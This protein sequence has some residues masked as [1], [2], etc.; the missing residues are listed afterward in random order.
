[1]TSTGNGLVNDDKNFMSQAGIRRSG[2]KGT[3][4]NWN[5]DNLFA[6]QW[7]LDQ[8]NIDRFDPFITGYAFV[9][10]TKLPRFFDTAFATEFKA[11][12]ERNFKSFDGI[13]D[14]Q[15]STEDMTHGF[16]GNA[17]GIATNI[18][19]ENTSFTLKHQELQGSPVRELYQYWTTGIR[20]PESG[21]AHYHGKMTGDNPLLYSMQNHT[22]ELLYVVTDPSGSTN[23]IE[24]AAYYTN[25]FPTKIPLGHLNY[26][27]GDHGLAEIDIE[28]RGNMHIGYY[29]NDL[30]KKLMVDYEVK[31][32]YGQYELGAVKTPAPHTGDGYGETATPYA[33]T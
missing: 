14:I 18:N 8:T 33:T 27:S 28:F 17:M 11:L 6:G 23:G 9:I 7:R 30:A 22:G 12:T 16:T 29:V 10:W 21:L 1:M 31:K 26:S 32:R 5:A 19:K 15:L 20:D 24:F 25:V 4:V 2:A 13:S 3:G